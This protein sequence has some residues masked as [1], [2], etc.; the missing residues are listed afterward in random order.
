VQP[1]AIVKELRADEAALRT[2]ITAWN[3]NGPTPAAVMQ[4]TVDR[5][6]LIR[7]IAR[8]KKTATEVERLDPAEADDVKAERDLLTLGRSTP[9]PKG[10][11][12][13]KPAPPAT[14]LVAWYQEAQERFGIRWQL[15]AAINFVESAFGRIRN[16]SG[17]GAQGPMQFEP[18]TWKAYGL[19]GNVH[20]PHDAILGAANYLAANHGA[21]NE[22]DALLHYNPS[23]LYVDAVLR[24]AH[25][26]AHVPTAFLE[27]YAR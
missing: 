1:P 4:L 25:R 2:A 14:K 18:A 22:R 8:S 9:P 20:D 6:G 23:P 13:L 11:I 21:T 26:M 24:Y 19:G 3:G 17:D 15:L 5:A 7:Q 12:K 10:P 27:Y 16:D